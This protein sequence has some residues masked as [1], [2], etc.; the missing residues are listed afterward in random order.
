MKS[1]ELKNTTFIGVVMD[2]NDPEKLGRCKIKVI[3]VLEEIPDSDL[4]WAT[5]WKDLNG[6]EFILP[7]NGKIVSVVFDNGNPYRPEYIFADHYN[8]NLEKKLKALSGENYTSMRALMFDHKTQIYS[9]D[10]EGLKIDYKYN[11]INIKKDSINVNLK[12]NSSI[13]N[14]GDAESDQQAVLG[15][16][17]LQWFDEFLDNLIGSTGGPYLGNL[18]APVI[19]NPALIAHVLKYKALKEPKFLSRNVFIT[20]NFVI[21]TVTNEM[22]DRQNV[23]QLGDS[24]KSTE[25]EADGSPQ[26]SGSGPGPSK[27]NS[28]DF[29]PQVDPNNEANVANDPTATDSVPKS[30]PEYI[31]PT[32]GP[33]SG[34]ISDFSK[35]MVRIAQ[36]QLGVVEQPPESNSGPEVFG[37]YQKSTWIKGTGWFWCAAFIC[38]LFKVASQKAGIRYSF[39]LPQTA[40]A[41]DY[42]NWARTNRKFIELYEPP[43]KNILPGDIIIFNFSHIGLSIGQVSDGKIDC[44]EGNTD[45][46]G[47]RNG[48]GVYK[49]SRSLSLIK[50][51]LRIKY[52][53]N[54][55]KEVDKATK[56]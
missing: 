14:L 28:G 30:K 3:D 15:T 19:A 47:G 5:P 13:L 31:D 23:N 54:L 22:S 11:N 16:N 41:F 40:G 50:Q 52:N 27:D 45:V 46:R 32:I 38:Y 17:F 33:D 55:V 21:S 6:N 10:K 42:A 1:Q 2:N 53:P 56:R 12:D 9:N 29:S 20:S 37:L 24:Y 34:I 8:I 48:G 4:P 39:S 44:I 18:G 35:E 25:K 26:G 7:D 51:V 49:K 43:F 36:T